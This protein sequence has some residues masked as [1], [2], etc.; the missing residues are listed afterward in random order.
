MPSYEP[1]WESIRKYRDLGWFSHTEY[2]I[3]IDLGIYSGPAIFN[4]QDTRRIYQKD[5]AIYKY[6]RELYGEHFGYKDFI[7]EVNAAHLNRLEWATLSN[8]VGVRYDMVVAEHSN[9]KNSAAC[10]RNHNHPYSL[11]EA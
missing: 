1:D 3:F 8:E 5:S 2:R 11:E 6:Y 9:L 7:P 4:Q 10:I